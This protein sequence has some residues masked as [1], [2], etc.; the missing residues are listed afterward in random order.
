MGGQAVLLR[1]HEIGRQQQQAVGSGTLGGLG[2]FDRDGRA[3]TGR[4]DDRHPA[5]G[6]L[7]RS[8][9]HAVDFGRREREELAGAARGEQAGDLV[10][11]ELREIPA[12][13]PLV[14]GEI[15]AEMRD[16]KGQQAAANEFRHLG[17]RHGAH[18]ISWGV[19]GRLTVS[20][21]HA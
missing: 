5:G 2:Q 7:H 8:A 6:L 10:L 17:G 14:E 3:V 11:G 20:C 12:I 15:V 19:G 21:W 4:R 13:G 18:R 9:E 16:R 1:S